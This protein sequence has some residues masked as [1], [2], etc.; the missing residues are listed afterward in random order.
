MFSCYRIFFPVTGNS[1]SVSENFIQW[2]KISFCDRK[3]LPV[4]GN[5]FLWQQNLSCVR[6]V[7]SKDRI[8]LP[9][10][11]NFFLGK[12]Y[13][14][15]G[16]NFLQ[17]YS[18]NL[19]KITHFCRNL[20]YEKNHAHLSGFYIRFIPVVL[21]EIIYWKIRFPRNFKFSPTLTLLFLAISHIL[22][23]P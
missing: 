5:F 2:Q 12:E 20:R 22:L 6:K 18:K 14:F 15:S 7:S 3:F 21:S 16:R 1:F 17:Y 4:S 9:V 13:Y 19:V 10:T 11:Q 8:F 23:L